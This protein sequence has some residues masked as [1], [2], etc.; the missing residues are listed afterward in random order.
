MLRTFQLIIIPFA[1]WLSSCDTET[2]FVGFTGDEFHRLLTSD[3]VKIWKKQL[4]QRNGE[5]LESDVCQDL[6]LIE[7]GYV[8][9]NPDSRYFEIKP[10][11]NTCEGDT[12]ILRSGSW[13]FMINSEDR[14]ITDTIQFVTGT[15]TTMKWIGEISALNLVLKSNQNGDEL[16]EEF[17]FEKGIY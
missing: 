4:V 9:N 13:M 15:D 10:D 1:W 5:I 3:S 2:G 17:A 16:I 12:S 6:T 8:D 14:L 11:P 7:F